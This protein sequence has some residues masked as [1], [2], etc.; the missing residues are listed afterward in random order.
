MPSPGSGA[1]TGR[2][3][4]GSARSRPTTSPATGRWAR[5]GCCGRSATRGATSGRCGV[6]SAWTRGTSAGCSARSRPT[7]SS[8]SCRAT[9]TGGCARPASRAPVVRSGPSSTG[10]ATTWRRRC[11]IPCHPSSATASWPRST[12]SSACSPPGSCRSTSSTPT[13]RAHATACSPTT[14]ARPPVPGR[15]RPAAQP[16]DPGR[17][18]ATAPRAVRRGDGARRGRRVRG[19][20]LPPGRTHRDQAAVG[21]SRHPWPGGRSTAARR[22]RGPRRGERQRCRPARHQRRPHRGDRPVPP[23]RLPRGCA[24]QRRAVRRPLV[25]EA[26]RSRRPPAARGA[27]ARQPGRAGTASACRRS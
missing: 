27:L 4:S 2:T 14:A 7:G 19:A 21:R 10:A 24:V 12:R 15:V 23:H 3:R 25:R 5:R 16:A 8:R 6:S 26:A 17:R 1:S 22:P 18:H 11:S 9:R 20:P 13:R